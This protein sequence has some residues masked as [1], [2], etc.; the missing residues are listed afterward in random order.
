MHLIDNDQPKSAR[1]PEAST[2][3]I[4]CHPISTGW[5]IKRLY[6]QQKPDMKTGIYHRNKHE[7]HEI[8]NLDKQLSSTFEI[9]VCLKWNIWG[10]SWES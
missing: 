2:H 6:I 4:P 9:P 5:C 3:I 10:K 1:C 8:L 7:I